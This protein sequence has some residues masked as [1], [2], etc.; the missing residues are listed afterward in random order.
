MSDFSA[1]T[2]ESEISGLGSASL[3]GS[4]GLRSLRPAMSAGNISM[5][6]IQEHTESGISRMLAIIELGAA[7]GQPPRKPEPSLID[8]NFLGT[9]IVL[10]E[11]HPRAR[12][13][14][15]PIVKELEDASKQLDQLLQLSQSLGRV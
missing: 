1:Y 4:N 6:P 15:E 5:A 7:L 9:P 11:L 3:H 10:E 2:S 13:M 12:E 8:S 14:F